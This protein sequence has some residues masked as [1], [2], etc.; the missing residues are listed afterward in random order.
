M[1]RCLRPERGPEIDDARRR[2]SRYEKVCKRLDD[3][4]TLDAVTRL[5]QSRN[6]GIWCIKRAKIIL[7][8]LE[9]K[10]VNRDEGGG[11]THL[12]SFLHRSFQEYLA[13]CPM[14][15]G[16]IRHTKQMQY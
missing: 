10:S 11:H 6:A 1:H 16:K 2:S 3:P 5:A 15:S 14:I 13:D 9:G 8:T 7:E 4:K 12:Y